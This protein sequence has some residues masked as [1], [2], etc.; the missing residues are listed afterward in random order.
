MVDA[1][2]NWKYDRKYGAMITAVPPFNVLMF[3]ATPLFFVTKNARTLKKINRVLTQIT[4]MPLALFYLCVFIA[5]NASL[6]P[7]A[8]LYSLLQKIKNCSVAQNHRSKREMYKDLGMFAILGFVL[9]ALAET[10][11]AYYFTKQLFHWNMQKLDHHKVDKISVTAFKSLERVVRK[12]IEDQKGK[13]L[14]V[15]NKEVNMISTI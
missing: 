11:D 12:V 13:R 6:T 3:F 15:S 10:K 1:I 5:V 7:F 9:L 14:E 8:F 2:G 4:Y